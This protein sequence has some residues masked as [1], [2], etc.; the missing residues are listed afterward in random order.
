MGASANGAV[1]LLIVDGERRLD[2][3]VLRRRLLCC[4]ETLG[5]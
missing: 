2:W 5:V 3:Q 1:G 4:F